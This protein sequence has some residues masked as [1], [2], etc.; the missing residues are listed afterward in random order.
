MTTPDPSVFEDSLTGSTPPHLVELALSGHLAS[1]AGGENNVPRDEAI[2]VM[3]RVIYG[4][5]SPEAAV[6]AVAAESDSQV[7]A[8][9]DV[10]T[11]PADVQTV[12]DATPTDTSST[13]S[14]SSSSKTSSSS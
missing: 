3:D 9:T 14:S 8:E 1:A 12:V 2:A 13:T 5:E 6:G 11:A 7:Q 10:A 4:N